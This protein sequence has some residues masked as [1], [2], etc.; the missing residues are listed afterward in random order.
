MLAQGDAHDA[1]DEE[2]ARSLGV[3][4]VNTAAE[5]PRLLLTRR[6][7]PLQVVWNERGGPGPFHVDF[8]SHQ[9][10]EF[11]QSGR[12]AVGFFGAFAGG[13][14]DGFDGAEVEM[15]DFAVAFDVLGDG[16]NE[17]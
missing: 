15:G 17:F 11:A 3:P 2:L 6:D 1:R 10:A 14:N 5:G 13:A 4:L 9:A 8:S 16:L 12:Q 7:G